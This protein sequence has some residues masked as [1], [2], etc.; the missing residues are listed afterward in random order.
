MCNVRAG[1]CVLWTV[2]C[3]WLATVYC[4]QCGVSGW[5]LCTV[6][7]VVYLAGYCVLWTVWCIWLA[8]VYCEQC[9]VSGL[10]LYCEQCGICGWLLCMVNSVVYLAGYCVLWT[11]YW[12]VTK[13]SLPIATAHRIFAL[14]KAVTPLDRTVELFFASN[15]LC[16]GPAPQREPQ[17]RTWPYSVMP[18]LRW[19]QS[20]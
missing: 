20:N 13:I 18:L 6:N 4:E 12:Q 5:L 1:Y 7:S 19:K 14:Q 10:L 8:T 16:L 11:A 9:G 15:K 3:I 17:Q 2:W